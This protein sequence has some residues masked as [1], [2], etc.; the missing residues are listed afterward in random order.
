MNCLRDPKLIQEP[1]RAQNFLKHIKGLFNSHMPTLD[2]SQLTQLV[3]LFNSGNEAQFKKTYG[4]LNIL[5]Y[6]NV[7]NAKGDLD[8]I[9]FV[10]K[11][12]KTMCYV[13]TLEDILARDLAVGTIYTVTKEKSYP[14]PQIGLTK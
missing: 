8:G 9:M 7:K 3:T 1:L 12:T 10:D 5:N 4:A 6:M 11:P 13:K 14:Y 2:G